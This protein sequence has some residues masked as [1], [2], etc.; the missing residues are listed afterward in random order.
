[1]SYGESPGYEET[2]GSFIHSLNN[3]QFFSS[4]NSNKFF[5]FFHNIVTVS[6][7][8]NSIDTLIWNIL[9]AIFDF[10]ICFIAC[11][12]EWF[13]N[14]GSSV[15][16]QGVNAILSSQI[17]IQQL[18][19]FLISF[20]LVLTC[21]F[22]YSFIAF[23]PE[24]HHLSPVKSTLLYII[25]VYLPLIISPLSGLLFGA[26]LII[27]SDMNITQYSITTT[28]VFLSFIFIMYIATCGIF[29]VL[30]RYS[31]TIR[32]GQYAFWRPPIQTHDLIFLFL[33]GMFFPIRM[34]F[35]PKICTIICVVQI[36]YG[37]NSL[38][39]LKNI[40]F[41]SLMGLLIQAKITIDCFCF[42][43]LTIVNVWLPYSMIM[44][45]SVFVCLGT[46][47]TGL[48]FL[49]VGFLFNY[50]RAKIMSFTSTNLP[51]AKV[52]VSMF[53]F[54]IN[55]SMVDIIRPEFVKGI[56]L[57]RFSI[58]LVPD[59][60]RFCVV[61]RQSMD[62][63][64]IPHLNFGPMKR[65]PLKFLAFQVD[66]FE[67]YSA[68]DGNTRVESQKIELKQLL[69]RSEL[70]LDNFW[71]DPSFDQ[72]DVSSLGR[73]MN[74]IS[75]RFTTALSS[76]P[77]SNE[78]ALLWNKYTTEI[79]YVPYPF[80][81]KQNNLLE[82]L[83]NPTSTV[84]GYL[85]PVTEERQ[86]NIENKESTIDWY[87][88]VTTMKSTLPFM[89]YLFVFFVAFIGV[90]ILFALRSL[91]VSKAQLDRFVNTSLFV[92]LQTELSNEKLAEIESQN[93]NIRPSDAILKQLGLTGDAA[94]DFANKRITSRDELS[95]LTWL[96]TYV[97]TFPSPNDTDK[98]KD[99]SF[100][101]LLKYQLTDAS[102]EAIY[103][104]M[105]YINFYSQYIANISD[106][107]IYDFSQA[108]KIDKNSL[109][110]IISIFIGAS[111]LLF[112]FFLIYD[113]HKQQR[114]IYTVKSIISIYKK[115]R[116]L[117]TKSYH[118]GFSVIFSIILW[119]ILMAISSLLYVACVI[120]DTH[121]NVHVTSLLQQIAIISGISRTAQN[122]LAS[123]E[124][125]LFGNLDI[126]EFAGYH[127]TNHEELVRYIDDLTKD[128]VNS[129]FQEIEPLNKWTADG[130]ESFSSLLLDYAQL[131]SSTNTT[132]DFDYYYARLLYLSN[133][134][135]L[136][137][138]T[139]PEMANAA[140]LDMQKASSTFIIAS[141]VIVLAA[142]LCLFIYIIQFYRKKSWYYAATM[143][144]RRTIIKDPSSFH[145]I[146]KM[147]ENP[148]NDYIE[149]LPFPF[150][151]RNKNDNTI[152]YANTKTKDYI[153]Y[154]PNQI[155]G[156]K[157]DSIFNVAENICTVD[158]IN[159]KEAK[160][161][162]DIQ[163]IDEN[164]QMIIMID[165]SDL[166]ET[167]QICKEMI[168]RLKPNIESLPLRDSMVYVEF[169][170]DPKTNDLKNIASMNLPK[171][172]SNIALSKSLHLAN[173][174]ENES[175]VS[176][177]EILNALDEAETKFNAA[178]RIS[179]GATFYTALIPKDAVIGEQNSL[180]FLSFLETI[181]QKVET[182][183]I[184]AIVFGEITCFSL[185]DDETINIVCGR[186][187]QRAHDCI[188]NGQR[189]KAY[190][191]DIILT[192]FMNHDVV[193]NSSF[194]SNH[195]IEICPTQQQLICNS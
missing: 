54:G 161:Q 185:D 193:E 24:Q 90:T 65:L 178:I 72:M 114:M 118:I 170:L 26:L 45:F 82:L 44:T 184:A 19:M 74:V 112:I 83:Y 91:E 107:I 137:D 116:N 188:I 57:W 64:V 53:R 179:C 39:T 8:P 191:D 42:P 85:R 18:S 175:A 172:G 78:I 115:R 145:L 55:F 187:V 22:W 125:R 132:G 157:F 123:S 122:Y 46:F 10:F 20:I 35:K 98:C 135:L 147:L 66:A 69:N 131:L 62:D 7:I 173:N 23:K 17:T 43:I 99:I 25:V 106:P 141:L 156:Q 119:I 104:Q 155:I 77:H 143:Y 67:K 159:R 13:N 63:I 32:N 47:S 60:V 146:Q 36:L 103:C 192:S 171:F 70:L 121:D 182:Q 154:T 75:D 133:I 148:K 48:S 160:L 38:I 5:Y 189:S 92:K 59:I 79:T 52:M 186:T 149:E 97:N 128:G 105:L 2:L 12:F 50:S 71:T 31:L 127:S 183:F 163:D 21:F 37:I 194:F 96:Y 95:N 153:D 14:F 81:L 80:Q 181:I 120:L 150:I 15:E 176:C 89:I 51:S 169:R 6:Y 129:L 124:N 138:Y 27:N 102:P 76:F 30:T 86:K 101:L 49:A 94:A 61:T 16:E 158:L 190:I 164:Y 109:M 33:N 58:D 195:L 73:E 117:K 162:L 110:L 11:P 177:E 100:V 144:L 34:P 152:S 180:N 68:T 87:L 108:T 4:R 93:I 40:T 142:I 126:P 28:S 41:I 165:V 9:F 174:S 134:S 166:Y 168:E 136:I 3:N 140:Q 111:T 1:M 139:L 56:A 113:L 130:K 151:V 84:Y 167:S 88:R 29:T